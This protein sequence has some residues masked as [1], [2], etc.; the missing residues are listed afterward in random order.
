MGRGDSS[1]RLPCPPVSIQ[2]NP[3]VFMHLPSCLNSV[4][5]SACTRMSENTPGKRNVS[6]NAILSCLQ[7][8]LSIFSMESVG[9]VAGCDFWVGGWCSKFHLCRAVKLRG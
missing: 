4:H 1:Y 6:R 9:R 7:A 2:I 5:P 8:I 3:L